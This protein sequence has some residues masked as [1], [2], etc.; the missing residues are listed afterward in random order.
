MSDSWNTELTEHEKQVLRLCKKQRLWGFLREHRQLLFSDEVVSAL[1]ELYSINGRGRPPKDVRQKALAMVVQVAFGVADYE[2]PTLTVVDQR[3][4]MVLGC[5]G[6]TKPLLSQGS[7][8]DFRMRAIGGGFATVLLERTIAVAR[9]T[10]GF[11]HKRLR[12]LVDSS[13]L[14]G[15]GRVEDTFNLIGRAINKLAGVAAKE[16]GVPLQMLVEQADLELLSASSVKAWLDCDWSDPQARGPALGRLVGQ[17]RGLCEWLGKALEQD[18]LDQPPVS[19]HIKL[20]EKLI[21]QDLEPDPDDPDG[22][23]LRVRQGVTP[24]RQISISDGDMR[25]GRKSKS[26]TF[27]GYKRHVV[28]DGDIGG[29]IRAAKV[30]AGNVKEFEPLAELLSA[31]EKGGGELSEVHVD[32]GYIPCSD[33][34]ARRKE[35]LTIVSK[36]PTYRNGGLYTK[37]DFEVNLAKQTATCPAGTTVP[38]KATKTGVV[39]FP[40]SVCSPCDLRPK[41]TKA[42]KRGRTILIHPH[43]DF[44]QE[45]RGIVAT[46][47]GRERTRQRIPVEHVLARV[48]QIQGRR[49]RYRGLAKNNFHLTQTAIVNNCYV[50]DRLLRAA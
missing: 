48:G 7:V 39:A 40:D 50:L 17:F 27:N 9:E 49:A 47:D 23:G 24:D 32:R 2:V 41:C 34:M 3:W 11:D 25:H 35:G 43:E 31:V 1:H 20:V 30:V 13:P 26:K 16:A 14:L 21:A 44:H 46:R 6:A 37:S 42:K 12:V 28:V 38:I 22:N 18:Q 29:L 19:D 45:L 4:Q 15:A 5:I 36:A 33:L 8:H 10:K